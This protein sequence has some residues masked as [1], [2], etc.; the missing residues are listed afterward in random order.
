MKIIEVLS[1]FV[2]IHAHSGKNRRDKYCILIL[3]DFI[4]FSKGL[5][6]GEPL[7]VCVLTMWSSSRFCI[8]SI[9]DNILVPVSRYDININSICREGGREG[10]E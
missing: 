5:M 1:V 10:E 6:K 4:S 2:K 9:E 7:I 8:S 3:T